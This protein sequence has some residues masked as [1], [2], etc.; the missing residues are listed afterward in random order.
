MIF[1]KPIVRKEVV[2][3]QVTLYGI[4]KNFIGI[5]EGVGDQD[6]PF[7]QWCL[8]LCGW[9]F[10]AHDETPWCSAFLNALCFILGLPRSGS[11]AAVSWLSIGKHV[12]I[13]DAVVGFDICVFEWDGNHH[14]VGL[15]GGMDNGLIRLL[16]GNQKDAVSE[17]MWKT[18]HLRE[19]RRIVL[20]GK[21]E[22]NDA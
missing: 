7:I 10:D 14:H 6:H 1:I 12:E 2:S 17:A 3:M 19:V 5:H 20:S 8:S 13:E 11:A 15:Y 4:A 22:I 9:G 18:D 21:E 16:G